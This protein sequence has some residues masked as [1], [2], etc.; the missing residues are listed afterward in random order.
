MQNYNT[1]NTLVT[2]KITDTGGNELDD[3]NETTY[4]IQTNMTDCSVH[5]WFKLF[6]KIL[7]SQGFCEEVIM[8]GATQLAFND[9][10]HPAMMDKLI[11]EYELNGPV[12][13]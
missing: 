7:G 6:E 13:N 9:S 5:A 8:R 11:K 3:M 4:E 12:S 1:H 10:R 2:I